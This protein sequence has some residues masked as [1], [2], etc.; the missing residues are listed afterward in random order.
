MENKWDKEKVQQYIN[1]EIEENSNLD[2]KAADA[3]GKNDERKK[4]ITKDVSAM[5]NSAG[6]II[7][8]GIRE[9][10]A[11]GKK[12]LPEKLDGI[13]R[14]LFPK[15]WLE[16][17][18]N[19]IQPRLEGLTIFPVEIDTG[20][21]HVVYVV[22]ILQS[23]TAH[24]AKDYRYYKRFNFESV[25]MEDYEVRDVMNRLTTPNAQ[26]EF[27]YIGPK[28]EER[29][30]SYTLKIIVKNLGFKVINNFKLKF[31]FPNYGPYFQY[32]P[33]IVPQSQYPMRYGRIVYSKD[34]NNDHVLT[35]HSA[36]R[37]F[38]EDEVDV[39]KEIKLQYKIDDE[40]YEKIELSCKRNY[41]L[42]WILYADNMLPKRDKIPFSKLHNY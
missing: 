4:E 2:Y 20:Q 42:S 41:F 17:I 3:L 23:T 12:H 40:A 35:Y 9:Y 37:L 13:D 29:T 25:P 19:S 5:A 34:K 6:G 10:N 28:I 1:D 11:H 33:G 30:H 16:H 32:S 26:V 38:P 31:T 21:N 24:Q 36:E 7:I 15:E 14:I 27:G 39:G 8:Y 18:I 22:E